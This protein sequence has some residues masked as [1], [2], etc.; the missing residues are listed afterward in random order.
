MFRSSAFLVIYLLA[1]MSSAGS[2]RVATFNIKELTTP[3]LHEAGSDGRGSNAQLR[4]AAAIIQR[5]RPDILLINEID[6]DEERRSN[7]A[8]FMKQYLAVGQDEQAPIVYEHIYFEPVNTGVPTRLDLNR[9]GKSDGPEDAFGFG[10]Y[11]GQYGMALYS[12]FPIDVAS[13]RTFQH[14]RWREMP[15]NLCPDGRDGKPAYYG[16]PAAAVLRLSSKSHWD[17]PLK[18]HGRVLHLLASHPTPPVFDGPEDWNG[19]RNFDEIRFWADYITGG[20][21]AAYI[22]DDLGRRGGLDRGAAGASTTQDTVDSGLSSFIVLGD[23][24]A[25]PVSKETQSGKTSISQ[26]LEHRRVHDP[27]PRCEGAMAVRPKRPYSGDL[28]LRTAD[29]GRADFI[30][31]SKDIK[32]IDAGIFWPMPD[33]PEAKLVQ[34]PDPAS[35][36]RLVW[37]DIDW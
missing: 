32:V 21:A 22:V 6:F 1:G 30:L 10:R 19:R 24:N 34:G 28:G 13:V 31:P 17:V 7:A 25:D 37:I 8:R 16:E 9:D 36:H 26:L 35:D 29:F 27:K 14:L 20:A 18:F 33:Q 5:V 15:G 2:V 4:K 23:L 12:R 11:P 3:K